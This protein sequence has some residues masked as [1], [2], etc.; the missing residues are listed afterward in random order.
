MDVVYNN[1]MCALPDKSQQHN[2]TWMSL[3][4]IACARCQISGSIAQW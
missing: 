4:I 3:A 2:Y 1:Y